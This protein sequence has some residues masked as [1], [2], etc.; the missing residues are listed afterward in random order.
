[1]AGESHFYECCSNF[2]TH[3]A[4]CVRRAVRERQRPLMADGYDLEALARL[5]EKAT[6]GPWVVEVDTSPI[7]PNYEPPHVPTGFARVWFEGEPAAGCKVHGPTHHGCDEYLFIQDAELIAAM[8]NALPALLR[9]AAHWQQVVSLR[10][11]IADAH[12]SL[13]YFHDF[14]ADDPQMVLLA[15]LLA[16]LP[17]PAPTP[18]RES[19]E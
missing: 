10:E 9:D 11:R 7:G 19:K 16:L 17:A 13:G 5:H 3:T 15:E 2:G 8:R 4:E 14:T 18:S 1:M 6:Q 12:Y